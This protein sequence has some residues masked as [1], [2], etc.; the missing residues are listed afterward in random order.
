MVKNLLEEEIKGFKIMFNNIDIDK[1]GIVI[2]EEYKR[3]LIIFGF[4]V[5][6]I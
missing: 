6:E 1:I 3:G 4:K 5:F 2:F